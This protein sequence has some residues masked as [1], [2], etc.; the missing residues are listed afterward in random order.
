MNEEDSQKSRQSAPNLFSKTGSGGAFRQVSILHSGLS[1]WKPQPS[2]GVP[3]NTDP[4]QTLAAEF[5]AFAST[6]PEEGAGAK[7]RLQIHQ[8]VEAIASPT[9]LAICNEIELPALRGEDSADSRIQA[10]ALLGEETRKITICSENG[11]LRAGELPS[12]RS[13]AEKNHESLDAFDSHL[14][15]L[16]TPLLREPAR[17]SL[18]LFLPAPATPVDESRESATRLL[19]RAHALFWLSPSVSAEALRDT[20]ER[21][22]DLYAATLESL[23]A[24]PATKMSSQAALPLNPALEAQADHPT[25]LVLRDAQEKASVLFQDSRLAEMRAALLHLAGSSTAQEQ[26]MRRALLRL[27]MIL[28]DMIHW[29]GSFVDRA[30]Q[31]LQE[32]H[33]LRKHL[34]EARQLGVSLLPLWEARCDVDCAWLSAEEEDPGLAY[35]SES[36]RSEYET[37][38]KA[39]QENHRERRSIERELARTGE[40]CRYLERRLEESRSALSADEE[41]ALKLLNSLLEETEEPTGEVAPLQKQLQL[42]QT[43]NARLAKTL[44]ELAPSTEDLP[45][46]AHQL[47]THITQQLRELHAASEEAA[48]LRRATLRRLRWEL[49]A[50]D[51]TLTAAASMAQS[52][53]K[54]EESLRTLNSRDESTEKPAEACLRALRGFH[55]ACEALLPLRKTAG[56]P[57]MLRIYRRI[58][59]IELQAVAESASDCDSVLQ[60]LDSALRLV[61][62]NEIWRELAQFCE[63]SDSPLA[64]FALALCAWL[65]NPHSTETLKSVIA[66]NRMQPDE[67]MLTAVQS[68][69]EDHAPESSSEFLEAL[70]E[71][72]P[73]YSRVILRTA[74][75]AST[76]YRKALMRISAELLEAF[77]NHPNAEYEDGRAGNQ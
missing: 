33:S 66:L 8:A 74:P 44:E 62:V 1:S 75:R 3:V 11:S 39:F 67:N 64:Q 30:Q 41:A 26:R 72:V 77:N 70:L 68:F 14:L 43:E 57:R 5:L 37:L 35:L 28:E 59:Q 34:M 45:T 21:P 7:F 52:S 61:P 23:Y 60:A 58:L 25:R 32:A 9:L 20:K 15:R 31:A 16:L 13:L 73:Q 56:N 12:L 29:P 22:V 38:R 2:K 63:G 71:V 27:Q 17:E 47:A 50:N 65:G 24:T 54:L 42:C 18:L 46:K 76:A 40:E 4:S 49:L 55:H 6:L 19:R 69:V 53:L 10:I 36:M 51:E 48:G